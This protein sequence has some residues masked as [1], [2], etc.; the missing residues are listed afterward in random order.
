MYDMMGLLTWMAD[1]IHELFV[2][3]HIV[4]VVES[5]SSTTGA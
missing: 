4:K 3:M 1:F 5:D 2:C